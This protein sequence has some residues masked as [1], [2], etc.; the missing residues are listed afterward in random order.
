LK[1]SL[2]IFVLLFLLSIKILAQQNSIN[3]NATLDVTKDLLNIEQR[4][5]YYNTSDKDLKSIFLHNWPNSFKNRKTALSKRFIEAYKKNMYFSKEK[6]LGF[7]TIKNISV[8]FETV[9]FLELKNQNDVLE[10]PLA[11]FLK[12]DDSIVINATYSVKIPNSKFTDY[13]KTKT[14]YQL[15]YWYLNPAVFNKKWL[16]MSNL[17]NDDL[18]ES[19]TKY[20]LKLK[21]PKEYKINSNLTKQKTEG[22]KF[23]TYYFAGENKTDVILSIDQI[24]RF[25]VYK[26][27]N[28]KILT[29]ILD[30]KVD[31][32]SSIKI[33]N[34]ELDFLE[35]YLGE[36]P[37][38]EIFLDKVA[39]K[40]D[41]IYGL[42]QLP[43]FIRPF[44]DT[45][46]TDITLFKI[47]TK[48]Y[49]ESTILVNKR[50]EY[51]ITDGL[52]SYLMMEY[53]NE[54]YPE[55]KLL[56]TTSKSW[57]LKRYNVSELDFNDK[58]PFI[59]QLSARSFL[60]QPLT[61][62]ADSLSNFN[63]K[64]VNKYKAGL[65]FI[66]LKSF[67]GDSVLNDAIKEFYFKNKLEKVSAI[68]FK[69]IITTKT[70]QDL[71]WFFGDY[72]QT[73]KK[74]D[75]AISDAKI[76]G[77]SVTIVIKNKRNITVPVALYGLKNKEIKFKKWYSN[78]NNTKTIKLK[79][80]NYDT[81]SLN[82]E[83]Q[84]PEHNTQN[85][86]KKIKRSLL[87]KALKFSFIKDI[88]DPYYNQVFYQ[89][90]F[91][92]NFY[93]GFIFGL[94][95]HNKPIIKRNLEL[96]LQPSYAFKSSSITG[97]FAF[98]YN[99]YFEDTNIYKIVYGLF[100]S[101]QHYAKDLSY[102]AFIPYISLIF[103]RKSLRDV[104]SESI[105]AKMVN[106]NRE[107]SVNQISKEQDSYSI[108]NLSYQY[109]NPNIIKDFRYR[110]NFEA[111][112][113]F[114][115]I[116]LDLRYRS[117]TSKDTQLD[118]RVF[119]GAFLNNR[120]T[121]DYFSFGL[122]RANDYLFEL[123]YF[124]RSESSGLFSQQFIIN[125][126]GFKSVLPVRY[127]NQYMLSTNS[128][129]GLWKWVEAYNGTA[130]LKNKGESLYFAYENGVRFNFIH[131]ILEV[132]LPIYSNNGWEISQKSYVEKV[133]FTLTADIQ[134]IYNFFR[135]GFL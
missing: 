47:L 87:N 38:K 86:Q 75:Y 92:Y 34:R 96:T 113:D 134:S 35:K 2:S 107:T 109:S 56:G 80:F 98:R 70:T 16:L 116:S 21:L 111:A 4:I 11:S 44:S 79:N 73:N 37:H 54:F 52:Q 58:Y 59:Y 30:D 20:S 50:K 26:T 53:V 129:I 84:Y 133:R 64:I 43:D 124:G 78:I 66:Y 72:I 123:N 68:D 67:L 83:Q 125:Q 71:S 3:I 62:S 119:A 82:Y 103:K 9:K 101:T 112:K 5:I 81:F 115:K 108:F 90:N 23:N 40:K 126:G 120:T 121:G 91:D 117:L 25:K 6:D 27:K 39:Q 130:F 19:P 49:I 105:S 29:D 8:N 60:D 32:K 135:R 85:N 88:E 13:G 122:D 106:I 51:W 48:K 104:S 55:V 97:S 31:Y 1:Q 95:L 132:Y 61:T 42:S 46:K 65:S 127:A 45:F 131:N 89:P 63:R 118:F 17:N 128:S 22:E 15:R 114:S 10:I 33:L 93:D 99:Q 24:D 57:L 28:I 14:G 102:N 36:Y 100:G 12:K 18:F 110:F 77:D 76:I 69:N 94:K 41:P 74:I 7:S